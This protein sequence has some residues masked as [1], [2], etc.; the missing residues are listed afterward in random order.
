MFVEL[1]PVLH[2][3][4]MRFQYDPLTDTNIKLNDRYIMYILYVN[5]LF[6]LSDKCCYGTGNQ[7]CPLMLLQTLPAIPSSLLLKA[8]D[9]GG[10]AFCNFHRLGVP[11][12]A[13]REIPLGFGIVV[14]V[15]L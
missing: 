4:L 12:Q 11:E 3:H 1:P 13:L 5:W 7:P 9:F 14:G 15:K 8:R 2:L 6:D 10:S